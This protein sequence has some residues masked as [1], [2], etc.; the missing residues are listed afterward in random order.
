MVK[1]AINY[2]TGKAK[3][4]FPFPLNHPELC[5]QWIQTCCQD[6]P[7]WTPNQTSRVCEGHF[8]EVDYEIVPY[9][10]AFRKK[11]RDGKKSDDRISLSEVKGADLG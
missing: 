11:L 5:S 7:T 1:C 10:K 3:A 6:D 8:T 4:K 2:C 9:G